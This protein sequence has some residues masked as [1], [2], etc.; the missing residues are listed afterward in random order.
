VFEEVTI[1]ALAEAA[2]TH[3]LSLSTIKHDCQTSEQLNASLMLQH[4]CILT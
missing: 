1:S 3:Q 4:V 2:K